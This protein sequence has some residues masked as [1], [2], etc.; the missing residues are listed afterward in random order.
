MKW[1]Y[2][3]TAPNELEAL[4]WRDLLDGEGVSAMVRPGDT[5]SYLGVSAAPCRIMV[6]EDQ[7]QKAAE[8]LESRLGHEVE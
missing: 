4:M 7:L 2:L 5:A 3:T 8:I 6:D 1:I